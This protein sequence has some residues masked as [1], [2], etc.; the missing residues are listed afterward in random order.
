MWRHSKDTFKDS[1]KRPSVVATG[2]DTSWKKTTNAI[3]MM[4]K[5]LGINTGQLLVRGSIQCYSLPWPKTFARMKWTCDFPV[6]AFPKRTPLTWTHW[7]AIYRIWRWKTGLNMKWLQTTFVN[8]FNT[9]PPKSMKHSLRS[10]Q[11]LNII[12]KKLITVVRVM[13]STTRI[14]TS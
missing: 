5:Q 2:K 14:E 3:Y 11:Y 7:K 12:N 1:Q 10:Y 8:D 4:K 13:E 6:E 9:S